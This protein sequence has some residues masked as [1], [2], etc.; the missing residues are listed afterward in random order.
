MKTLLLIILTFIHVQAFSQI[1]I[2][3]K[4]KDINGEGLPGAIIHEIG[5]DNKANADIE[6]N[7]LIKTVKDSCSIRFS[8]LGLESKAI[9]FTKDQIVE[10]TLEIRDYSFRW[11]TI[12]A[13]YDPYNTVYGLQLSNGFDEN[14]LI[15]FEDFDDN[16]LIKIQGQTDLKANYSYGAEIGWALFPISFMPRLS[17]G[18]SVQNFESSNLFLR[19][20]NLSSGIGYFRNSLIL[21]KVGYQELQRESNLGLTLGIEQSFKNLYLGYSFGY[22]FDYFNQSAYLQLGHYS[23]GLYSFR[24]AY[25]RV[26]D[27]N[28][29]TLGVHYTLLRNN[30]R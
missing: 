15:H 30:N 12:G 16:F 4:V 11:F 2:Q 21:I 20:F 9:V 25:N 13:N 3:G 1:T 27:Y 17:L 23:E 22:Y 28:L 18:Y 26:N 10:V 24:A 29:L 8:Y 7:F 5:T 6:G 14:P 19:D